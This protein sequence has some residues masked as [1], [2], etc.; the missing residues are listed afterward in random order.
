M[1]TPMVSDMTLKRVS[2][3]STRT[4]PASTTI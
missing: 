4:V 2:S 1:E 3:A